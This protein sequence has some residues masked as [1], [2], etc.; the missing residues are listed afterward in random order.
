MLEPGYYIIRDLIHDHYV[1]RS[2]VEDNNWD[3][4]TIYSL[5]DFEVLCSGY[6]L[7]SSIT[8]LRLKTMV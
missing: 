8:R 7:V 4:K 1:G 6:P 3:P 2:T 5:H